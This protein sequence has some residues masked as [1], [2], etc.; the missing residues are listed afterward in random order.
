MLKM[1]CIQIPSFSSPKRALRN[2]GPQ[3]KIEHTALTESG[4][5]RE[6][7]YGQDCSSIYTHR[8]LRGIF[9]KKA[10]TKYSYYGINFI[11]QRTKN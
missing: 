1:D 9:K 2:I 4:C 5:G 10:K 6:R 7:H 8:T 3:N 11:N